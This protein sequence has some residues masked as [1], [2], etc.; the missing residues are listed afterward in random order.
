M[1]VVK[2]ASTTA[3]PKDFMNAHRLLTA[4]KRRLFGCACLREVWHLLTDERSRRAVE[5]A[6]RFADGQAGLQELHEAAA[7]AAVAAQASAA[8]A[9][10][11]ATG[12]AVALAAAAADAYAAAA[13]YTAY[14]PAYSFAH[15]PYCGYHGYA[16]ANGR[17]RMALLLGDIAGPGRPVALP[18]TP[19]ALGL[20][21]TL[22]QDRR[23]EDLPLL[24]DVLEESGCEDPDVL[25]HCRGPGPHAAGCWVC[26]AVLGRE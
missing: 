13:Y 4:R 1:R 14:Y 8:A 10:D 15:Y 16:L 9:A 22:Y 17:R 25:A 26:D 12:K 20:A 23:W 2:P 19:T 18:R 3:L 5:V 21:R 24:A 11:A 6:E 7:A